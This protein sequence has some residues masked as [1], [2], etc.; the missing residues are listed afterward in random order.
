MNVVGDRCQCGQLWWEESGGC[1]RHEAKRDWDLRSKHVA[2]LRSALKRI[3]WQGNRGLG[4]DW[5]AGKMYD[6]GVRVNLRG[7]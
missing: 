1:I 7:S 6:E 2:K 4:S 3:N 5:L